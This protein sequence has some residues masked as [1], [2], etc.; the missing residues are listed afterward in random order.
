MERLT[1]GAIVSAQIHPCPHRATRIST[2]CISALQYFGTIVWSNFEIGDLNF[3]RSEAYVKF[4]EHLDEAGGFYYERWASQV[5][6]ISHW[7][8]ES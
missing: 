4:F 7:V 1:T 8:Y 6:G 5:S 3:W 2:D